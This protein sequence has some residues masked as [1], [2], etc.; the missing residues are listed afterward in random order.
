MLRSILTGTCFLLIAACATAPDARKTASPA[1]MQ[2]PDC[3]S[4]IGL[5]TS[6]TH[7]RPCGVYGRT[8][9]KDDLDRTGEID[10][11]EA[12]QKLDPSITVHH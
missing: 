7:L 4:Q 6:S 9:S 1:A 2:K 3:T 11:G 5:R 8:Y 12:L 10:V